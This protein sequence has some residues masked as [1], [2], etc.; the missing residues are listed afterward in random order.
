MDRR[1]SGMEMRR[2]LGKMRLSAVRLHRA[3]T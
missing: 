1:K 2:V 3:Q